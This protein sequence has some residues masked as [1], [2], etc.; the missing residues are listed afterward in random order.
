MSIRTHLGTGVIFFSMVTGSL[1]SL[2]I[3]VVLVLQSLPALQ[4]IN[5]RLLTTRWEPQ[6]NAFGL[7][8]MLYGSVAV[9]WIALLVALPIGFGA[10]VYLSEM[11]S[12]RRRLV[13]KAALEALAGI[14]SIVYG[15]I[16]VAVLSVWI[17]DLFAL[18]S[19]RT[20][21]TAGLLLS[22]MILPLL[23][24]LIDDAL[25]AVPSSYREAALALGMFKTEML[26]YALLPIART[27]IAAATLLAL[28]RAFGETMAVMLVIGGID[29]LPNPLYNLLVPGQTLTSKLGREVAESAFGT[30]HF[31][32]L[33][34]A[35]LLLLL[36][37]LV[38]TFLARRFLQPLR[39]AE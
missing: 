8:S 20:I 35:G 12:P 2:L 13:M 1:L 15:L 32:V 28:G 3:V 14:P 19:G 30:L 36:T 29:R 37:V 23:I 5:V 38:L 21:L 16:G 18:S 11:C 17:E 31:S 4:E 26:R 24:T 27:K 10:G 7:L 39:L 25:H 9:T 6:N 33:I 34:S 22:V